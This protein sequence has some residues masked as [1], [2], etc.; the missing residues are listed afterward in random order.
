M[1]GN[2]QNPI[3]QFVV[4]LYWMQGNA[5]LIEVFQKFQMLY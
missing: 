5:R 1:I 2:F 4:F 3:L